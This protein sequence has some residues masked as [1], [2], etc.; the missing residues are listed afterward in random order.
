M[1]PIDAASPAYLPDRLAAAGLVEEPAEPCMAIDLTL[2]S[3]APGGPDGLEF[4]KL[5]GDWFGAD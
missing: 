1:T 5:V 4:E 3:D 2:L